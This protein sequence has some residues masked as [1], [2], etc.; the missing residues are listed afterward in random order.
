MLKAGT[1]IWLAHGPTLSKCLGKLGSEFGDSYCLSFVLLK[2]ILR[3]NL[4]HSNRIRNEEVMA[5]IR[6]LI[7]TGNR[8]AVVP[9]EP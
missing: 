4:N 6:K 5:K 7:E 3:S 9:V 8:A 2:S 1:R